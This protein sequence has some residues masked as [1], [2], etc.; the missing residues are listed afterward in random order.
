MKKNYTE[1]DYIYRFTY[2][3]ENKTGL[4]L[5]ANASLS[6]QVKNNYETITKFELKKIAL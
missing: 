2:V 6:E 5:N 3:I 4:L 1:Y